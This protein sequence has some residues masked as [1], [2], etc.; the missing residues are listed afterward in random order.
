KI[1]SSKYQHRLNRLKVMTR[2]TLVEL[3]YEKTLSMPAT[4]YNDYS[5]TT[6]MS[7]DVDALTNVSEMFHEA[8]AQVL[9]VIVGMVLLAKQIG[10][11]CLVPLPL[12]Y[13]CSQMTR[14]VARNLRPK[15]LAW[16]KATQDR[17]NRVVSVKD[18]RW[19]AV[20][21]NAS[22]NALGLFTPAITIILFAAINQSNLDAET[23]YTTLAILLLVTH[24]ANMIMT[25]VPRAIASLASFQRIQDFI[26]KLRYQDAREHLQYEEAPTLIR[27]SCILEVAVEFK[28]V[29]LKFPGSATPNLGVIGLRINHGCIIVCT[30]PTGSGKSLLGLMIAGEMKPSKGSVSVVS[31]R[32]GLCAQL[33]WL[34]R[35]CVLETITGFSRTASTHNDIWYQQVLDA[36]C[37]DDGILLSPAAKGAGSGHARLSGGQRQ[38]VALARAAY[39]GH[40]ILVLDDPFSALDQRTQERV[41]V[42][43][44]GPGGLLRNSHTIVFLITNAPAAYSLADRILLLKHGRIG[45]DGDWSNFRTQA[46]SFSESS[47][48][49]GDET[50][51]DDQKKAGFV[52]SEGSRLAI[53]NDKLDIDR[54]S[55]DASV[56]R[57]YVLSVGAMNM[58]A[59]LSCTALYSFFSIFP[60]YW[61]KWWTQAGAMK[62]IYY[63]LGYLICSTIAWASTSSMLW[64]NFIKLAPRSGAA[65]HTNLLSTI[66]GAPLSFFL[67]KDTG[68]IVNRFGQD[69]QVIDRDLASA[70]AALCTQV[71]KLL[72][73]CSLLLA[74]QRLLLFA[75]PIYGFLI[76]IIQK[77]YLRTARQLRY[78]DLESRSAVYSSFLETVEGLVTIM[79]FGWQ[80]QY[81]TRNTRSLDLSQRAF[82]LFL[83]LQR[84]LNVVLD[85]AVA[86]VVIVV[87]G[88]AVF[89]STE[90]S[91]ADV[92]IALNMVLVTNTTLLRLIESWTTFEVS[93][94]A[95][96]RL[97]ELEDRVPSEEHLA[98]ETVVPCNWPSAG[99][100]TLRDV[101]VCHGVILS[102]VKLDVQAG[103]KVFICGETGR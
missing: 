31:R 4:A 34:P 45:F 72:M 10:W 100:L 52:S 29:E 38:R 89:Y 60:H 40:D 102:D 87:I 48:V 1:F 74:S 9:E 95:A 26:D 99:S 63:M 98:V 22:A 80:Q 32:I 71:F 57:Y 92:G 53:K 24:P 96:A 54:R 90:R 91:S 39:Q 5:A 58:L 30:G 56:Y 77:V 73:Q 86:V 93:V 23:A 18:M 47:F 62:D 55:G 75:L 81:L 64:V 11:F 19:V 13:G 2:A 46:S 65:L 67:D 76:Y 28:D 61:L 25:I 97:K 94:G 101:R 15:Q 88:L 8:W 41:I 20:L 68:A 7:T 70:L 78:L 82:Y 44:L 84:W 37:I 103:S 83:C 69:M 12:I 42:N 85:L 66:L 49:N 50:K 17:I 36:C 79:A 16:N 21:A 3:I 33:P 51:L 59:L 14:Y 27:P 35:Q 43:L 6:L